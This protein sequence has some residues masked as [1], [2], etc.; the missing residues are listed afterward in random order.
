[1]GKSYLKEFGFCVGNFFLRFFL[2]CITHNL[3]LKTPQTQSCTLWLRNVPVFANKLTARSLLVRR[4]GVGRFLQ[5]D[6][7]SGR[8]A[9]PPPKRRR[10]TSPRAPR[11]V[12]VPS[13]SQ[14]RRGH[15]M[16]GVWAPSSPPCLLPG[17]GP[18]KQ[19]LRDRLAPA[20]GFPPPRL[21]SCVLC[22]RS[23]SVQRLRKSARLPK[24]APENNY[25]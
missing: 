18:Q 7:C 5:R 11:V 23:G 10:A 2:A 1:M 14:D 12:R 16:H 25:I 17:W 8:S 3:F 20:R 22:F 6:A 13:A 24:S 15:L 4:Q 21:C 9:A 19:P